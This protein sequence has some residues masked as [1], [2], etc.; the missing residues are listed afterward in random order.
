MHRHLPRVVPEDNSAPH[1]FP[2][3]WIHISEPG[4]HGIP[5]RSLVK[6][7]RNN[8]INPTYWNHHPSRKCNEGPDHLILD[9][10]V[11]FLFNSGDFTREKV[12]VI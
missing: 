8:C 11:L 4:G 1:T 10:I 7:S 5:T 6:E 9:T 3:S 2:R 12:S